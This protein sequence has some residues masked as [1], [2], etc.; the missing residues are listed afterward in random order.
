MANFAFLTPLDGPS[1][2]LCVSHRRP[3][4]QAAT[5]ESTDETITDNSHF[6]FARSPSIP[7]HTHTATTANNN[8]T[9]TMNPT[10]NTT[11]ASAVVTNP[12]GYLAAL[13]TPAMAKAP[14]SKTAASLAAPAHT[15]KAKHASSPTPSSVSVSVLIK[16]GDAIDPEPVVADASPTPAEINHLTDGAGRLSGWIEQAVPIEAMASDTRLKE[17]EKSVS[18]LVWQHPNK[19]NKASK[20]MQAATKETLEALLREGK[21]LHRKKALRLCDQE[22]NYSWEAEASSEAWT[23]LV[24]GD[25]DY[26]R[27]FASGLLIDP[28]S[29]VLFRR[30]TAEADAA[31][32]LMR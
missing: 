11:T 26:E 17:V 18:D 8:N 7:L 19:K 6:F 24:F 3:L 10:I 2:C 9:N 12:S 1:S 20:D 16:R 29:V 32:A 28:G 13:L 22:G 21:Q 4:R 27:A 14:R 23:K 31:A 30:A 5:K 25:I 15:H